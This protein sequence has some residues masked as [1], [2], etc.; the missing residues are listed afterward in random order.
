MWS[1]GNNLGLD[2]KL[3]S[4]VR[5]LRSRFGGGNGMERIILKYFSIPLFRSFNGESGKFIPLFGSLSKR[6]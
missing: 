4:H 2:L 1:G 3:K 5:F 6:K